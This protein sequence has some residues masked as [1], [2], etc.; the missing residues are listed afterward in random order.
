MDNFKKFI[1]LVLVGTL[2]VF[3]TSSVFAVVLQGNGGGTGIS[4]STSGQN[5][6]CLVQVSSTPFLTYQIEACPITGSSTVLTGVSPIVVSALVGNNQTATCPTCLTT[7]TGLTVANF[8]TSSISQF[9]NDSH[10]VT[11][12]GSGTVGPSTSTYVAV[13]NASGTIIGYSSFNFVSSTNTLNLNGPLVAASGVFSIDANGYTSASTSA[14]NNGFGLT[15]L[16]SNGGTSAYPY[17]RVGIDNTSQ[18]WGLYYLSP[19]SAF[20]GIYATSSAYLGAALGATNGA[21]INTETIAPLRLATNNIVREICNGSTGVCSFI[22]GGVAI[23]SIINSIIGTDGSG[24]FIATSSISTNTGNWAGTW[25]GVNSSTFYLASNPSGYVTSTSASVTSTQI[26]YGNSSNVITSTSTFTFTSSTQQLALSTASSS[27][28]IGNP[29]SS[30]GLVPTIFVNTSTP[31]AVASFTVPANV[32]ALMINIFGSGGDG[33]NVTGQGGN[34]SAI[35]TSSTFNTSTALL[36]CGGGGGGSG[37][38]GGGG[39]Y[40]GIGGSFPTTPP[41]AGTCFVSSSL[42]ATS[43][44]NAGNGTG[45]NFSGAGA[46]IATGTLSVVPGTVYYYTLGAPQGSGGAPGITVTDYIRSNTINTS[47]SLAAGGHILT[48]GP[49]P[50]MGTCGSGPTVLGNDTAGVITVGSGTVTSC[51][52]NFAQAFAQAP[53]PT[54]S[55]NSTAVT[56]DISSVTSSSVTFGF[57]ASLGGGK[58]YYQILGY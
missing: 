45:V 36:Y 26:A 29:S 5:G 24:N 11:S 53:I 6:D 28:I 34:L 41:T 27:E 50:T 16:N 14:I 44:G 2:F 49:A 18:M 25:Q 3:S 9:N 31:I 40:G 32:Q 57:S 58:I 15:V 23:P 19:V 13:F 39:I 7:S 47:W 55:D 17:I 33:G 54:E 37:S 12:T 4:T 35:G 8:A 56:G 51:T 21:T 43:T 42:T 22:N 52:L 30:F 1:T 48:G 38:S 46:G 20:G 10:Y